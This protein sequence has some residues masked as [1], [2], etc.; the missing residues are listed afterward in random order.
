[1]QNDTYPNG[2]VKKSTDICSYILYTCVNAEYI[3]MGAA[4]ARM[5]GIHFR[6]LLSAAVHCLTMLPPCSPYT[7]PVLLRCAALEGAAREPGGAGGEHEGA[8][9]EHGRAEREHKGAGREHKGAK[10][11]QWHETGVSGRAKRRPFSQ[12]P[13]TCCPQFGDIIYIYYIHPELRIWNYRFR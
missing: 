10:S 8:E 9:R 6:L 5:M 2:L 1:M 13:I 11:E 4:Q 7:P 3:I 12:W